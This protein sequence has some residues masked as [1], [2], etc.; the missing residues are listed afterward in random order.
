M[1][2]ELHLDERRM[3]RLYAMMA[4]LTCISMKLLISDD[5]EAVPMRP[6]DKY[7]S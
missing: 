7:V 3:Y 2:S 1:I 6:V 5:S 4:R